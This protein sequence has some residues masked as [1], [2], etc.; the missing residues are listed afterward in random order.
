MFQ[1]LRE[2]LTIVLLAALPFHAFFVTVG[3]R[4]LAG[5]GRPPLMAL[6][7]W[8][9]G[10]LC[11][12]LLLALAELVARRSSTALRV[13]RSS[14]ILDGCVAALSLLALLIRPS[15]QAGGWMAFA[16]GFKYDLLPL[17]AF[18]IL[19]RV[20]WS[21]NFVRRITLA[22]L[23][24]G[25]VISVY[26]IATVHLPQEFFTWLGYSDLHSLYLPDAPIA[27][28]QQIGG[29]A[30]RR[31]QSVMS[32]PNQL[33]L[34][35]LLPWTIALRRALGKGSIPAWAL[36]LLFDVAL[37]HTYSRAAWIGAGVIAIILVLRQW[38]DAWKWVIPAALAAVLFA[39]FWRPD[40][41]LRAASSRDHLARPL[42]AMRVLAMHPFGMGLG[43]AGPVSNRFGDACVFLEP[44]SDVSW[45]LPHPN[46]CVFVGGAQVQPEGRA[47]VCPLI[48]ENWYLQIGIELGI[49]GLIIYLVMMV[50]VLR[51]LA[52]AQTDT[53]LFV[54]ALSIAALVLHSFEDA[55][56]AFTAWVLVAV[57]LPK[58]HSAR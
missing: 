53:F 58:T 11:L 41:V 17:L 49:L 48:P 31:I 42:A 22:V 29:S 25:A 30:I 20:P 52:R 2:T 3:T 8:K 45:A 23:I 9:E 38:K 12:I 5:P 4:V 26:G 40:I 57:T 55:A 18:V 28:F 24:V 27:A 13:T 6:A 19:R 46:L 1:R 56:V 39:L 10:A 54:L 7:L 50:L 44:G 15:P 51:K 34:W 21:Q 14:D 43:S 16:Y 36:W 33:G 47:C 35:M 37:F 32:G